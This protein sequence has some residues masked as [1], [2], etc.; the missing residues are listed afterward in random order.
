V[1]RASGPSGLF[2][3]PGFPSLFASSWLWHATRWGG[4]FVGTYLVTKLTHAPFLSQLAGASIF[5]PMLLGGIAAGVLSD[6]FDRHRIIYLTHALL[7]PMSVVMA[8]LVQIGTVRVWLVFP[9]MLVLGIG[10]LVNMTSQRTLIYDTVGPRFAA[11]ALT[12]DTV[13]MASASVASTLLGGVLIQLV[14]TGAAIGLLSA[15][16]CLSALLLRRVPRPLR[17]TEP[18]ATGPAP[19][20]LSLRGQVSVGLGVARHSSALRSLLAVTVVVNIF[21]FSFIPL[22]PVMAE[23]LGANAVFTGVL[24][25]A[26]GLG[27]LGAGLLLAGRDVRRHGRVFMI[28]SIVALCGLAGFAVAPFLTLAVLSL[29]VAGTGQA[30]FSSMQSLLA[31]ESVGRAEQGAALGLLCTAVGALPIGMLAV[32]VCAEWLGAP[33]TL[34]TFAA[35]GLTALGGWLRHKPPVDRPL[36]TPA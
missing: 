33:L 7:I 27:Q 12:W 4:L 5:A 10:G 29:L 36:G 11:R 26:A 34:F 31:I 22:V 2:A 35:G 16:L 14:G 30:G 21:Y 18:V 24:A 25:S 3:V 23:R 20:A 15:A 28:G 17:A 6:R 19:P 32:G 8:V 13:G 1:S 9:F